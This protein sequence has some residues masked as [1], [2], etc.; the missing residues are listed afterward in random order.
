MKQELHRI[1][2]TSLCAITMLAFSAGA[3]VAGWAVG[4]FSTAGN[5]ADWIVALG[6]ATAAVGTWAIGVGANNYAREAHLQRLAERQST[7]ER[8]REALKR[9]YATMRLKVIGLTFEH[10][11]F[12]ATG[13]DQS[14]ATKPRGIIHAKCVGLILRLGRSELSPDELI[15]LDEDTQRYYKVL[16]VQVQFVAQLAEMTI[17]TKSDESLA[18]MVHDVIEELEVLVTD[19]EAFLEPFN[20][21]MMTSLAAYKP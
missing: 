4:E 21:D 7:Q 5:A 2:T 17:S 6:G 14:V 15:L 8:A 3:I 1:S 11:S 19:A 20:S 12:C 13:D 16:Q 18:S 9:R 10:G